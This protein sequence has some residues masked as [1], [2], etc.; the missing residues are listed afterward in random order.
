VI[1]WLVS[2][3]R[4]RQ[5]AMDEILLW[6]ICCKHAESEDDARMAFAVHAFMDPAWNQLPPEEFDKL[7]LALPYK[8]KT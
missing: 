4:A 2:K 3:W 1:A 5:R 7:I 6:P 8:R